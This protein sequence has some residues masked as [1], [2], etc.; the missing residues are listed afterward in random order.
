M[1]RYKFAS[2][3]DN[4]EGE[5]NNLDTDAVIGGTEED[6]LTNTPI[7]VTKLN[8]IEVEN[9]TNKE[10]NKDLEQEE[11]QR[12][13]NI[14]SAINDLQVLNLATESFYSC[15]IGKGSDTEFK[16][17]TANYKQAC[18][19]LGY[20][21][22]TVSM[23]LESFNSDGG[24][25]IALESIVSTIKQVIDAII[26]AIVASYEY[27]KKV[28]K[29][30]FSSSKQLLRNHEAAATNLKKHRETNKDKLLKA[31]KLNAI[32]KVRFVELPTFK[33]WLTVNG[34][35]PSNLFLSNYDHNHQHVQQVMSSYKEAFIRY[36]EVISKH[37]DF[38]TLLSNDLTT[39]F[40]EIE[41]LLESGD[42]NTTVNLFIVNGDSFKIPSMMKAASAHGIN[43]DDKA[44][45]FV[46]EGFLGSKSY[47]LQ[48]PDND[49]KLSGKPNDLDDILDQYSKFKV[50][51]ITGDEE[52]TD[53][54][55]P[56]LDTKE[57][58]EVFPIVA[59]LSHNLMAMEDSFDNIEKTISGLISFL[60]KTK[61]KIPTN[62][63]DI[64]GG[65]P[66]ADSYI[67]MTKAITSITNSW[68][69]YSEPVAGCTYNVIN[70]WTGYLNAIV[71]KEQS[72]LKTIG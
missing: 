54:Y 31:E 1:A 30:L 41:A 14:S 70:A 17:A 58:D 51:F 65:K 40:N 12:Q 49:F 7:D 9:N 50:M 10:L 59:D 45:L 19:S 23:S 43:A 56:C 25:K 3:E 62:V 53:G 46:G 8:V 15:Y 67:L 32:D 52:M 6:N 69:F 61:S 24:K 33:K 47:L 63:D 36:N 20:P 35:V 44:T 16:L 11:A 18:I 5:T 26:K 68:K 22:N 34:K 71:A 64:K 27:L 29:R 66:V 39:M 28:F 57:L 48:L 13:E 72:Y 4:D 37:K 55:L 2:F 60:E 38:K 42:D 21:T